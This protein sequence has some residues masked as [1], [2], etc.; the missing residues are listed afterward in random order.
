M[1]RIFAVLCI[2][3]GAPGAM[4]CLMV[5]HF[6]FRSVN[7]GIFTNIN[8]PEFIFPF[9]MEKISEL[10][11]DFFPVNWKFLE[12]SEKLPFTE[13]SSKNKKINFKSID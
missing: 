10:Q 1:Q 12:H 5:W 4:L 6:T 8:V 11:N 7:S 3:Q 2:V 9:S 13:K